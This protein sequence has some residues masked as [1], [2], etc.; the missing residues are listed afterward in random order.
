MSDLQLCADTVFL[1]QGMCVWGV[2]EGGGGGVR[3]EE[4]RE[5]LA[6]VANC[7]FYLR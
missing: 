5:G 7:R 2:E 1:A 3:G 4:V 6:D